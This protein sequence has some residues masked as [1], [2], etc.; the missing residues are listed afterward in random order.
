MKLK[1][2]IKHGFVALALTF[3]MVPFLVA[4][5]VA[6]APIDNSSCNSWVRIVDVSS[7]QPNINWSQVARGGVAGAYIK[8]T[9]DGGYTSPQAGSQRAGA[10]SVGIP[11]GGYAYETPSGGIDQAIA[12]ADYFVQAGGGT[13][14]LPPML[15]LESSNLNPTYTSIWASYWIAEVKAKT[16][17]TPILY[18]GAYYPFIDAVGNALAPAGIPFWVAAYSS[19]YKNVAN[20]CDTSQPSSTSSWPAW[21]IWQYTSVGQIPGI[22]GNVDVSAVTPQWWASATGNAVAPP[23]PGVNNYPAPVV[24][25]SSTGTSVINIQSAMNF[26]VHSNLTIDGSYGPATAAAVAQF[27]ANILHVSPADGIWGP[28]TN[29]AYN[30][31][32]AAMAKLAAAAPKPTPPP[33]S[34][35][36]SALVF[37]HSCTLTVQ[38]YGANNACVKF[39]QADLS[40]R[41]FPLSQDGSFGP[42]TRNAVVAFQHAHGLTADGVVG[43]NTWKALIS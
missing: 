19:G 4:D 22:D 28:Q 34:T 26:W 7:Y 39:L 36:A 30:S 35:V 14:T 24:T 18:S 13:G 3:G 20:A 12:W 10:Q 16:G 31:F 21:S 37:I 6:A 27:Q 33:A 2:R 15:D 8:L 32:T 43:A 5:P 11:W 9:E 25:Y 17:K 1:S 38:S 42:A 41:G 29:T 40:T 23:T